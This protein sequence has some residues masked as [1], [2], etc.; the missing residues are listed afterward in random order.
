MARCY[1]DLAK[2]HVLSLSFGYLIYIEI[3]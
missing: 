3:S 2:R 1:K